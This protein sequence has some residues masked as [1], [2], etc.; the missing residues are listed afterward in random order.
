M[1]MFKQKHPDAEISNYCVLDQ[2]EIE[3]LRAN[4]KYMKHTLLAAPY[5]IIKKFKSKKQI[6]KGH[7]WQNT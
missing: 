4:D 2:Q 6:G 3:K 5:N 7:R 1:E